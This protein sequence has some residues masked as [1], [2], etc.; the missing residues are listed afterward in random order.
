MGRIFYDCLFNL[1]KHIPALN[2][3]VV[4]GNVFSYDNAT[5]KQCNQK[6]EALVPAT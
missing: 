2:D 4:I 6:P 5:F 3:Q 1:P